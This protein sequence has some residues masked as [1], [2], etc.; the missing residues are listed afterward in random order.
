M[1]DESC[2]RKSDSNKPVQSPHVEILVLQADG[3]KFFTAPSLTAECGRVLATTTRKR[4]ASHWRPMFKALLIQLKLRFETAPILL[5]RKVLEQSNPE[6]VRLLD[7]VHQSAQGGAEA[8]TSQSSSGR[9]T[10]ES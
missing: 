5:L 1:L 9:D 8:S 10:Q 7:G 6:H 3:K 2:S 4:M